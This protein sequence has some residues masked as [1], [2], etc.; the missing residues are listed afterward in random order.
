M[1]I[2]IVRGD[3]TRL[4]VDAVVNAANSSL[5]GGGG[6]DGAIHRAAGKELEFACRMLNGCKPGQA[7]VTEG[8]NLTAKFIIHTVGPVWNGGQSGE[9]EFLRSCYLNSLELAVKNGCESIAFPAISCGIYGYPVADACNVAYKTVTEFLVGRDD[10]KVIFCC[11]G[12]EM[13][14]IYK[15]QER[16]ACEADGGDELNAR[17]KACL[18]GLAAGDALG[19]TLEFQAPGSFELIDDIVGGGPFRLEVGQWTDDT[20]M[21]LCLGNSL[22]RKKGFDA[23]DQMEQYCKWWKDG[24]FSVNGVCFD[25]GNTVSAAL[26]NFKLSGNP[27]AGSTD[28]WSAGN[29]SIM[30]LAPVVMAFAGDAERAVEMAARS[31]ATTHAAVEAVDGCRYM[32]GLLCG[33]FNGVS[34]EELLDF[35]EPVDGIWGVEP[36]AP[37]IEK[38]ARGSFK[39]KEPPEIAGTGYVVRSLEAALWA[40]HKTDNFKDG[41]L[42]AANLGDDADTT[43]AVYGQIAGA[44]Y[45]AVPEEWRLKVWDSEVI[46]KMADDLLK[47]SKTI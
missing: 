29:G 16:A 18:L 35:Y 26:Q 47:L 17:Y 5:L 38:V 42:L 14:E 39:E 6:V 11:F 23:K 1:Y 40:F 13:F 44:F 2:E 30:R 27:F 3:I 4:E 21:A 10:L 22:I 43:G 32:A 7:K 28:R 45:G 34:K 36:L 31:S 8:F 19:T 9:A 25:I 37:E 33:A 41:A 46:E 24:H 20:S 12:D 15:D